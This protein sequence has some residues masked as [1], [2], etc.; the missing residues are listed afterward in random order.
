MRWM[1][2]GAE[3]SIEAP[4][5]VRELVTVATTKL[6]F[7]ALRKLAGKDHVAINL[8]INRDGHVFTL[9]HGVRMF[10]WNTTAEGI[11]GAA[12]KI[13]ATNLQK[14]TQH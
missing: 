5:T 4:M 11:G 2:K 6:R 7:W 12:M 13:E 1:W 10:G 14:P 9:P 8:I 3:Y